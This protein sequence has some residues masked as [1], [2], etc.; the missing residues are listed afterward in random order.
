MV[1]PL[2]KNAESKSDLRLH[3]FL[4]FGPNS[5]LEPRKP[6]LMFGP[7]SSLGGGQ[8]DRVSGQCSPRPEI[9]QLKL[10]T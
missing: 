6:G 9:L 3:Q 7:E 10:W 4:G 8:Q 1:P 5:V 2:F